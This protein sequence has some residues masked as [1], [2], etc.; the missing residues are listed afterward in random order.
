LKFK[1]YDENPGRDGHVGKGSVKLSS[2]LKKCEE[3]SQKFGEI[4]EIFHKKEI[5]AK[6]LLQF[7]LNP[8]HEK[9]GIKKFIK[10][11]VEI[12]NEWWN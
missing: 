6:M 1:I 10:E 9:H 2:I 11:H 8:K 7:E 3:T 5:A 4:F 12:I